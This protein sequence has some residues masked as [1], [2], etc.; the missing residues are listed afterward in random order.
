MYA[1]DVALVTAT[2]TFKQANTSSVPS[3]IV[4]L[5]AAK[6]PKLTFLTKNFPIN[7]S[8]LVN[9]VQNFVAEMGFGSTL[10]LHQH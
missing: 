5:T 1:D 2:S 9:Y 3:Q 10:S 7:F 4:T 8:N 6:L